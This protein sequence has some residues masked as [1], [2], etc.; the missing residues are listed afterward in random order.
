MSAEEFIVTLELAVKYLHWHWAD[1]VA[2]VV[3]A[4]LI[5]AAVWPL[6]KHSAALLLEIQQ[7]A[8]AMAVPAGIATALHMIGLLPGVASLQR[9]RLMEV[10]LPP[11]PPRPVKRPLHNQQDRNGIIFTGVA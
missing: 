4:A 6:V 7:G 3:I 5:V 11:P 8:D 2:S 10:V 9:S 1:P